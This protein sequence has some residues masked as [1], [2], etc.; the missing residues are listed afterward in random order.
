M[1]SSPGEAA[2]SSSGQAAPSSSGAVAS[3]SGAAAAAPR[4]GDNLEQVN[5][6]VNVVATERA[7]RAAYRGDV[8]CPWCKAQFKSP[9][10][11]GGV[12]P[13]CNIN[14]ED[15]SEP[16]PTPLSPPA[17]PTGAAVPAAGTSEAGGVAGKETEH[18]KDVSGVIREKQAEKGI[19]P[20]QS[21]YYHG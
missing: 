11:D 7:V 12:C 2:S 15:V 5:Y 20:L 10:P 4:I 17:A 19:Q 9:A 13:F 1:T 14:G 3:S 16:T 6:E 8:Q 18:T 21:R